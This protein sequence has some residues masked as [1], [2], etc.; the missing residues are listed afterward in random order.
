MICEYFSTCAFVERVK[1]TDPLTADTVRIT[2]CEHDKHGCARY[3]LLQ[4]FSTDE[5]P[6]F[7]WPND[8]EEALDM[9]KARSRLQGWK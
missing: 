9:M 8:E 7:L 3:G 4:V 1:K 6:D 2:Y 5:V